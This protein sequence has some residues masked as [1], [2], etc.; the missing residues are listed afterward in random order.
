MYWLAGSY[1]IAVLL[2]CWTSLD[3]AGAGSYRLD[4]LDL[5]GWI[6]LDNNVWMRTHSYCKD[7]TDGTDG[8]DGNDGQMGRWR[9]WGGRLLAP[10][11]TGAIEQER[12][13][14]LAG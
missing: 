5:I 10:A 11:G 14:W 9:E 7:G 13:H 6:Q 12:H 1:R 4:R 2:Y 8:N 3:L